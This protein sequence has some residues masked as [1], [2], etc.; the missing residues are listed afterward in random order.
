MTFN[1]NAM[2]RLFKLFVP[3]A[4]S[5][6]AV[7]SCQT[8]EI[9]NPEPEAVEYVFALGN[10]DDT[11]ALISDCVVWESGDRIG[12]FAA[13]SNN[14]YSNVTPSDGVK[15][16]VFSIYANGG[17]SIGDMIYC[18]YPY[19]NSAGNDKSAVTMSISTTQNEKD[20]MPMVSVPYQ[21][22]EASDNNQTAYAGLIQ[23]VNLGSVIELNIYSETYGDEK[24]LSAEFQA[25]Q[26]IAGSF[27]YDLT[28]VD[29]DDKSTLQIS[30]YSE[31]SVIYTPASPL[32][33]GDTKETATKVNLVVA[34]G[35]YTG[36][37]IVTTDAAIYTFPITNAKEFSRS[38]V[39]PLGVRLRED[40]RKTYDS[41]TFDFSSSSSLQAFGLTLPTKE[42]YTTFP[43]AGLTSGNV[44]LKAD[45][46][47][48]GTET[49]FH[50]FEEAYELRSYNGSNLTLSVS[51]DNIITGI[52]F[53]GSDIKDASV[54]PAMGSFASKVWS[55][56]ANP[57]SLEFS[58]TVKISTITVFYKEGEPKTPQNLAFSS[59]ECAAVMDEDFEEPELTG[60]MTDVTYSSSNEEVATVGA[61]G[62]V[63]LVGAGT[64]IITAKAAEDGT[65]APGKASY[66]LIVDLPASSK[67]NTIPWTESFEGDLS[68]YTITPAENTRIMSENLAGGTGKELLLAKDE[69]MTALLSAADYVG[70]LTLSFLSNHPDYCNV[71]S[72]TDGVTITKDSDDNYFISLSKVLSSF[73]VTIANTSG[74]NMRIDDITVVEGK[75]QVQSLAFSSSSFSF[76]LNSDDYKNFSAPELTGAETTVTYSSDNESVATVDAE[77]GAVT[78]K[79]GLGTATITA[80]AA[81]ENG[82]K[83]A[84]AS[85]KIEVTEELAANM[86]SV[87]LTVA[88]K[89]SVNVT[90][91]LP[92]GATAAYTQTYSKKCQMTGGN[93]VTYTL[94][95]F[96]G[97]TIKKVILSMKSN[98][99]AGAGS[100]A[101]TAGDETIASIADT[102]FDSGW[103][104]SWS[105]EYVD[106][107]LKLT[108]DSYLIKEE[109]NVVLNILASANSLYCQSVTIQYEQN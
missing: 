13:A 90:G 82:Y 3:F 17:L 100:L 72:E 35:T 103:Y 80:T 78:L 60:A 11:K 68:K 65:Y 97:C 71:S 47:N 21:V 50:F 22:T 93:S 51:G 32:E 57:L 7:D 75:W 89:T 56:I 105:T 49:R 44:T 88:S 94:T 41:V 106:I 108:N 91:T 59:S 40:V 109:E 20:A 43:D 76:A 55:G 53:T 12:T 102:P 1:Q 9:E 96:E 33:I 23:F 39:K 28:S 10:A 16:A 62:S 4:L 27:T 69:S 26:A 67:I 18:Y 45:F 5:V 101:L 99:S 86:K 77:T 87:T 52:A 6:L 66:T 36:K 81:A 64:T 63:T 30:G 46:E 85:Y 37:V 31:K 61:D 8:T 107:D 83:A 42:E 92:S 73:E 95:G 48:A 15:P 74:S 19:R 2:K 98:Q 34:P 29:Y 25:D 58:A 14:S 38:T 104:G 84:I 79:G 54:T 70:D 24:I